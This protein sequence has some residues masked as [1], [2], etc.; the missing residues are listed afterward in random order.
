M[1]V[2]DKVR[3]AATGE[4]KPIQ[5]LR[6]KLAQSKNSTAKHVST[7]ELNRAFFSGQQWVYWNRNKIERP[8][9]EPESSR[10]LIE[11]DRITGI[12]R[13]EIAKMSKQRPTWSV[14]PTTAEGDDVKAA[15]T[16]EKILQF[17]WKH[18]ALRVKLEDALLW[19]RV[20][21]AG[22]WK[23]CWDAGGGEKFGIVI[24][25]EGNPVQNP[26]TGA[27]MKP[28][29]FPEGLPEGAKT[30]SLATGD[31]HVEVVSPFE[32]FPDPL[33]KNLKDCEWVIQVSLQSKD[34]VMQRWGLDLQADTSATTGGAE[35]NIPS[36]QGNTYKGIKVHE[37]WERPS[38]T[39]PQGR[40]CVWAK[41][42]VLEDGPNP[43]KGLPYVM[44]RSIPVPGRFWPMAIVELLRGPQVEL[45]KI[46]SQIVENAQRI[47]NPAILIA[48]TSNTKVGGVPGE[49]IVY[50]DTSVNAKP[51]YLR[52]PDM[53][54]Y[55]VEQIN[56][57]EQSLQEISG[58]HEV[59]QAQV[60][61]GV[62]AASAINLL[63]EADDTRLGPGIYDME[64]ALADAGTMMLEVV[65]QYWTDERVVLIAG[66]NHDLD[67]MVFRGAALKEN[68]QVEVQTGSMLP[69]SKAARQ[70]AIQ[71]FLAL[72]FQ[73]EGQQPLN[74]RFLSKTLKDL[75][76]GGLEKFY[77]DINQDEAQINRE[78]QELSQERVVKLHV[79][80]NNQLHLEGHTEYQK[81]AAYLAL[82]PLPKQLFELHTREHREHLVQQMGA[83]KGEE[84]KPAES[85][86]YKDAPPDVRRQ[87]EE[88]AGLEP[89]HDESSQSV[90][91][92]QHPEP[93]PP[94]GGEQ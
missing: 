67:A 61:P 66:E 80:D 84:K 21:C 71:D 88:Q 56:R 29:D 31:V 86:N 63:Q 76:A 77:G 20:C 94:Q 41:E 11:D 40:R 22:F 26:A 16:G 73:Y 57:I 74:P 4:D 7:W 93:K 15:E 5:E 18:L 1:S 62:K 17:L 50:D 78:N 27:P 10:V 49:E 24:D 89:S 68:T 58:Q 43:Y 12:V 72:A 23:V 47:G 42:Q 75:G 25:E 45:N 3:K 38:A 39:N 70:A 46:K 36:E 81:S 19:S 85:L 82:G 51:E 14:V 9:L 6:Q 64:E 60:P 48:Q 87:I 2:L 59:S 53:P 28:E 65:A 90:Q 37:Y 13:T 92:P 8:I 54:Q 91:H 79:Y 55:V 32:L 33:A 69:Q 35:I 44:F 34:Y 30:K 52:P 83:P